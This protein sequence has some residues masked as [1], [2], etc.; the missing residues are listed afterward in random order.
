MSGGERLGEWDHIPFDS[1]P[2]SKL[3]PQAIK[4]NPHNTEIT[5]QEIDNLF[6]TGVIQKSLHKIGQFISN[7]F[8]KHKRPDG[9][10]VFLNLTALNDN[11]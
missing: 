3:I 9:Y 11:L 6:A 5:Q 4:F 1:N 7:I 10:R 8:L 2:V